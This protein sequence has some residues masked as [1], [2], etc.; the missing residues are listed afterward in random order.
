[1]HIVE[2]KNKSEDF[3]WYDSNDLIIIEQVDA[4]AVYSNPKGDIVIRQQDP[5][6][7][8]D[9]FVVIP[10]TRVNEVIAALKKEAEL[11][12]P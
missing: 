12:R 1:M 2:K 10:R 8:E 7:G 9:P 4:I 11:N 3:S 5:I 6:D